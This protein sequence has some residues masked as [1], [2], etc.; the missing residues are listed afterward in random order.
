MS[1]EAS[2]S[3][4]SDGL[5][6]DSRL[7]SARIGYGGVRG[8]TKRDPAPAPVTH[9]RDAMPRI[10]LSRMSARAP[11]RSRCNADAAAAF[12]VVSEWRGQW[13]DAARKIYETGLRNQHAV[14]NQAIELLERQVGR[15]EN[16]PEMA[17]RMRQHIEESRDQAGRLE[18]LLSGLG[19]ATPPRKIP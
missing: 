12:R 17:D 8:T 4:P 14:E 18:E 11:V 10:G 16:Y 9:P 1:Q 13:A 7:I 5:I 3:D 6:P 2:E 19:P 15:L